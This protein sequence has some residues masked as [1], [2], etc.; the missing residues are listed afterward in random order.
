MTDH[1]SLIVIA[2]DD[3]PTNQI[4]YSTDYGKTW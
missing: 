4:S 3:E 1:G 2:P